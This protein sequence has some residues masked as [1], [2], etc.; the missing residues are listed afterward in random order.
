[1]KPTPLPKGYIPKIIIFR[2][3]LGVMIKIVS[4]VMTINNPRPK[5][6]IPDYIAVEY[7]DFPFNVLLIMEGKI[8]ANLLNN[9][10]KTNEYTQIFGV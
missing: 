2:D 9:Q 3:N 7:D 1:M 10:S 4:S 6:F 8:T 5:D